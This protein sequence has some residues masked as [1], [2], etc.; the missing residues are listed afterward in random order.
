MIPDPDPIGLPGAGLAADLPPAADLRAPH[1]GDELDPG[2]TVIAVVSDFLG[3]RRADERYRRLA[4]HLV[5]LLPITLAAT[6]TLGVAPLLFVQTLYGQFFYTSSIL[7]AWPWLAVV[8]LV[9]VAYYGI[10][11][12]AWQGERLGD[13]RIWVG[14]GSA[15]LLMVVA[16]LYV[17]NITLMLT[18]DRWHEIYASHSNGLFLNGEEGT[19]VPRL[20]HFL[21]AAP[22]VAGAALMVY[23]LF[24][25]GRSP[26]G[27]WVWA[28]RY[29]AVWFLVSTLIQAAVG[30]L[31]LFR[32]PSTVRDPFVG[33]DT[34][35]TALLLGG[36]RLRRPRAA[37]DGCRPA[38]AKS[39]ASGPGRRPLPGGH[40][41]PD[42]RHPP[43]RARRVPLAPLLHRRSGGGQPDGPHRAV[44]RGAARRSRGCGL[45]GASRPAS[46]RAGATRDLM[47]L[48]GLF[49]PMR[50]LR[51]L[52]TVFPTHNETS[53]PK[54]H[55][56]RRRDCSY[57]V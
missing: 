20:F 4:Q 55:L 57:N 35:R 47:H 42:E 39:L 40:R 7:M 37:G 51:R 22:A 28:A 30:P 49:G 18:P 34:L 50:I 45:H 36:H 46:V 23:A 44:L 31:F 6:I 14:A 26:E 56:Y 12:Y 52:G 8:P 11:L 17:N 21:V 38:S 9:I 19:L 10:Y 54:Q 5:S 33:D 29:G 1:P 27:Y 48:A 13:R 16:F 41:E 43:L 53:V 2:R 32:L 25:K 3:R 15:L 24:I